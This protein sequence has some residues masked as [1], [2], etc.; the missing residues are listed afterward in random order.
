MVVWLFAGGGEAEVRGLV[1]FFQK[2]FE[3][4]TF[5]RMTPVFRRPGPRPGLRSRGY[6]RTGK[7]LVS[8]IKERLPVALSKGESCD[9]I[10]VMDDLDCRD[11]EEQKSHFTEAIAAAVNCDAVDVHIG[12]AAP[13]L[14]SW[15]IA[16]W[17][18][19]V[20]RHPDFRMRHERMRYW[21]SS[22]KNVSFR[23]PES[24]GVY[25]PERDCC[26]NKLSDAIIESSTEDQSD[27]MYRR[28]SKAIHTPALLQEIHPGVVM[29]KCP[30]F[31]L[32]IRFLE[33]R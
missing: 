12:F 23:D 19:S 28:Y 30:I 2:H 33:A 32:L 15:I 11:H 7:S 26:D 1:P 29:Q 5:R 17:D 4:C 13:E 25:D 10:L 31:G 18:H 22:V 20:A 21:L 16:D 3:T 24:Y 6:G 27:R 9:A 8:E 14:E